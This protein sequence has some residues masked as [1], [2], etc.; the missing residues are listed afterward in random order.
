VVEPA[1]WCTDERT[2]WLAAASAWVHA[3]VA[4]AGLGDVR[5]ISSFRERPWGALFSVTTSRERS[6]FFK[7]VDEPHAAEV[8]VTEVVAE[9]APGLGPDAIAL[10]EGRRFLLL[11]AH[12]VALRTAFADDVAAMVEATAGVLPAYAELQQALPDEA[13]RRLAGLGVP[14]RSPV[15]L[16]AQFDAFVASCPEGPVR[17]RLDAARAAV[18]DVCGELAAAPGGTTSTLD[19]ADLHDTNVVVDAES[20]GRSRIIDWGDAVVGHPFCSLFVPMRFLVDA[21]P[22]ADRPPAAR[23]LRDAYLEPWGGPTAEHLRTLELATWIAPI[24]RML[25]LAAERDGW[26]E[27]TDLVQRWAPAPGAGLRRRR[28]SP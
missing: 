22:S 26:D 20:D 16:P 7:A 24:V 17:A 4:G 15:H 6:L 2:A 13:V 28:S 8:P 12:G 11:G 14:D 3:A 9:R 19:H 5:R 23:R 27:I 25:A 18:E 1:P 21:L 10:D